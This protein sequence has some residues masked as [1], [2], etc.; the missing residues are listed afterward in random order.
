MT[1]WKEAFD[2]VRE[3]RRQARERKAQRDFREMKEFLRFY[4]DCRNEEKQL[5]EDTLMTERIAKPS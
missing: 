1:T 5:E 4:E 3:E 2:A